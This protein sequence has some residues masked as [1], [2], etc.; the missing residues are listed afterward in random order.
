MKKHIESLILL[1]LTP[2]VS[3][4][5]VRNIAATAF[6]EGGSNINYNECYGYQ[7][8]LTFDEWFNKELNK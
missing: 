4:D 5:F 7:A 3:K 1:G 2:N 8:E 6:E